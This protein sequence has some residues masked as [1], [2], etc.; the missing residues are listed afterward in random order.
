[1]EET[2]QPDS[3]PEEGVSGAGP[4]SM[5]GIT[6]SLHTVW[7]IAKEEFNLYWVSPIAYLVGAVWLF[8][9]GLFFALLLQDLN[10]GGMFGA[11]APEMRG[12]LSNMAFLIVFLAPALTMRLVADE[13]RS[14]THELLM[15]APVRDWEI[16]LGKWLGVWGVFTVFILISLLYPAVLIWRGSP[17]VAL[18][19]TSY[20]GYWLWAGTVLAVGVLAS[21]VTQFQ[22]VAFIL[23]LF[24]TLILFLAGIFADIVSQLVTAVAP[25][26]PASAVSEVFYQLSV[27]THYF[28][29]MLQRGLIEWVD[30][31]YFA[32]VIA[33]CLFVATQM[34]SS[35]RWRA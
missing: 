13:I 21:A 9:S 22:L 35:R 16:I 34:L 33:I 8:F 2:I 25:N 26:S 19:I 17:D 10:Q 29:T 28:D 27:R 3:L 14:G 1:M 7:T 12:V 5:E 32:G 20:L 4:S 24:G 11:A 15:T 23:G 6:R 30:I 31:A 18:L